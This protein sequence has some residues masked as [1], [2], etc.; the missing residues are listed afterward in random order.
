MQTIIQKALEEAWR[1]HEAL[2]Q[3]GMVEMVERIAYTMLQALRQGHK[4]YLC[5]NG[6]SA[7]E[8]QHLAAELTGRYYRDRAPLP[9]EALHVNT[10]YLTAVANDYGYEEVFARLLRAWGKPGD[11]LW[12]FSTSGSSPNILRALETARALGMVTIG[13]T[14]AGGDKM[15]PWCDY[16]LRVPSHDT[17]RIQEAHLLLGHIICQ[18]IEANWTEP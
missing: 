4:L 18:L 3:P 5:G 17:A 13:F 15:A 7:A 16:L 1:L 2:F 11:L 8:A 9:A 14:G 6:G 10:S 12:A